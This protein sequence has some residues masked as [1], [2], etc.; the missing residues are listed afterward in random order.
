MVHELRMPQ[1]AQSIVEGEICRWLVKEGD[2]VEREQ[3]IAEIVT[4]KVDVELPA[5][6][7]GVILKLLVPEGATVPVGA[8]LAYIG[9]PGEE[10]RA[11]S[12]TSKETYSS[13]TS[14][15]LGL[16][17]RPAN[18]AGGSPELR[19]TDDTRVY[20]AP[21]VRKL[22]RELHVELASIKGTG[23]ERRIT[24]Q[25]VRQAT[26]ARANS[27]AGRSS[28]DIMYLPFDGRR[29]QIARNLVRTK[30]LVPHASC[31]E[32]VD[33]TELVELRAEHNEAVEVQGDHVTYLAYVVC[34]VAH[35]LAKHPLLN[36]TLEDDKDRI[37]VKKYY[38][39]GIAVDAPEGL[40]VPVIRNADR[41]G[42]LEIAREIKSLSTRAR[43][44]KLSPSEVEG[45]T[46]TISNVGG[47]A[48]LFA[49]GI[50]NYPEVALLNFHRIQH[51]P[52]A[53][54]GAVVIRPLAYVTLTFD[55]RVADG[56]EVSRFLADLK[57]SL[58]HTAD[59]ATL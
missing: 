14:S 9:E 32:E 59:W 42:L 12:A 13:L 25:D 49:V 58:E 5:P 34:A 7:A 40:I 21:A 19:P 46:F 47:Q 8:P 44:N 18:S 11:G 37:A 22:A 53:V 17:Q 51:R 15:L 54:N 23:P 30:S 20:A 31:V 41:K 52:T 4:D 43:E 28:A 39:I 45:S 6:S 3:A 33:C 55:H 56:A 16:D 2:S 35:T 27:S 26:N 1:L 24:E 38:N 10:W 29:R 48:G 36:S 50:L 57:D